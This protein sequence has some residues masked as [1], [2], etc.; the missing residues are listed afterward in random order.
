MIRFL[1]LSIIT[2]LFS[3]Q[4]YSQEKWA[5]KYDADWTQILTDGNDYDF[6]REFQAINSYT[7]SFTGF[8]ADSIKVET[9]YM[10]YDLL[11]GHYISFFRNGNIQFEGEYKD[12]NPVDKWKEN[13]ENGRLKSEYYIVGENETDYLRK[14]ISYWDSLGTQIITNGMG[15]LTINQDNLVHKHTY[16]DGYLDGEAKIY[17]VAG[18]LLFIEKYNRG[19]FIRG[20]NN[21]NKNSY[22][23]IYTYPEYKKGYKEFNRLVYKY[24]KTEFK[25]RRGEEM[26]LGSM[27]NYV[28]A[29][30]AKPSE[31][32]LNTHGDFK[33]NIIVSKEGKITSAALV[34]T[35]AN[36][37]GQLLLEAI[38][39]NSNDW[40]SATLR[41]ETIDETL[42][43]TF[44]FDIRSGEEKFL[45]KFN[46]PG[47]LGKFL[48]LTHM[49]NYL[50]Y[51]R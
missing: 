6:F 20:I 19:K 40:K 29:T 3:I 49:P 8:S 5:L 32:D 39:N 35:R 48:N 31:I 34:D 43:Y 44:Y 2:T 46:K 37:I 13:Y 28:K 14:Y 9:G 51:M 41:G 7:S 36:I 47:N 25:N 10:K 15:Q 17:N 16:T 33:T 50:W 30:G 4:A 38:H 27:R 42:T 11:H 1:Y 24:I 45:E 12:G 21:S 23:S 26:S 18:S 22:T